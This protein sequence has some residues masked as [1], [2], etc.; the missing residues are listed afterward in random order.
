[1]LRDRKELIEYEIEKLKS[2]GANWYL[3]MIK[4]PELLNT[5]Q[6][7]Y[8]IIREKINSLEFDLFAVNKLIEQ[9]HK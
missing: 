8:D 3:Q 2:E 5:I 4:F 9:G 6:P 1:M 7:E